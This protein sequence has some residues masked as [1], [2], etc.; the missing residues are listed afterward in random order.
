MFFRLWKHANISTQYHVMLHFVTLFHNLKTFSDCLFLTFL[1]LVMS[2]SLGPYNAECVTFFIAHIYAVL[3]L[4][5]YIS[6][7]F[8]NQ[9]CKYCDNSDYDDQLYNI[10]Q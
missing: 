4:K 7:N 5:F 9:Y 6:F 8:S 1:H 2:S 3:D 10:V